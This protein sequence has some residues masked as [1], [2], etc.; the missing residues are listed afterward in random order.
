MRSLE[1]PAAKKDQHK[2]VE[3]NNDLPT[4]STDN[5]G[6]LHNPSPFVPN[7]G[8]TP[9]GHGPSSRGSFAPVSAPEQKPASHPSSRKEQ[10]D[11]ERRAAPEKDLTF[12][13][14]EIGCVREDRK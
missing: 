8:G 1:K 9:S 7:V 11:M 2:V 6:S 5:S 3:I 14:Y 12:V 4:A 10:L 13:R